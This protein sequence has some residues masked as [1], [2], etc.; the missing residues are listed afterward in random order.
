MYRL[1][2]GRKAYRRDDYHLDASSDTRWTVPELL[3][4]GHVVERLSHCRGVLTF[5]LLEPLYFL[6]DLNHVIHHV[7]VLLANLGGWNEASV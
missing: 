7:L 4:G 6:L 1:P 2:A 3:P 5:D